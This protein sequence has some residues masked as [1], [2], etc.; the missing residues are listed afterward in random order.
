MFNVHLPKVTE[1]WIEL[2]R[3][4]EAWLEIR[5]GELLGELLPHGLWCAV[6]PP[7]GWRFSCRGRSPQPASRQGY[8]KNV[9]ATS[10][11]RQER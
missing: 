6:S 4:N 2:E 10:R 8:Q 5:V 11:H 3:Q 1:I 7:N 9:A